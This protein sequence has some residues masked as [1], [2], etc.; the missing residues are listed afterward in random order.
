[1]R[2][3]AA[4][5]GAFS[6][7]TSYTFRHPRAAGAMLATVLLAIIAACALP[8]CGG[9]ESDPFAGLYWEPSTGRRVEIRAD[10][11]A[12]EFIYGAGKRAFPAVREGDELRISEPMGG[13]TIVRPGGSAG[14]LEMVSGGK[15]TTL[16]LLPQ[17]Q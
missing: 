17:H 9:S 16:E 10:G 6:A 12:Y 1:M 3:A 15:T 2:A 13:E 11:D 4:R 5:L 7:R 8:A 14:T